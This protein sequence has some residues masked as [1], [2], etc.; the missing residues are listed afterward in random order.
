MLK[1]GLA[2]TTSSNRKRG[3]PATSNFAQSKP[4]EEAVRAIHE[5]RGEPNCTAILLSDPTIRALVLLLLRA[6]LTSPTAS[7]AAA[8]LVTLLKS[9]RGGIALSSVIGALSDSRLDES[10]HFSGEGWSIQFP[11]LRVLLHGAAEKGLAAVEEGFS[12]EA[13]RAAIEVGKAVEVPQQRL[14]EARTKFDEAQAL[15]RR[16]KLAAAAEERRVRK[17]ADDEKRRKEEEA[18]APAAAEEEEKRRRAMRKQAVPSRFVNSSLPV[19]FKVKKA[20]NASPNTLASMEEQ[21]HEA[22]L[23]TVSSAQ[24]T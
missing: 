16:E 12:A 21:Q 22:E 4:C 7:L 17:E 9:D 8:I 10:T 19:R 5:L 13:V 11:E 2:T 23:A 18:A 20:D 24:K 1:G 6:G 3:E 15:R 14:E